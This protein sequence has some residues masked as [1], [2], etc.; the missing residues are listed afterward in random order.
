MGQLT[1]DMWGDPSLPKRGDLLQTN[2]GD[3]RERTWFI[4]K[5]RRVK[6]RLGVPR[7]K[8][9]VERWW[10]IEPELRVRLYH[11]AERHGGQRVI[12]FTRYPAKKRDRSFE[13]YMRSTS[14]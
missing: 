12:H 10:D 14:G 6:E 11:S 13:A 2:M 7:C 4:L 9:W 3:R 8:V 1:I 5:V